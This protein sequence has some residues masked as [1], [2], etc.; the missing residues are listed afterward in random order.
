MTM[1]TV[2]ALFDTIPDARHAVGALLLRKYDKSDIQ[3]VAEDLAQIHD[4]PVRVAQVATGAV[5]AVVGAAALSI[6]YFGPLVATPLLG[7]MASVGTEEID[8]DRWLV[9]E[10]VKIGV[11]GPDASLFADGVRDGGALVMVRARDVN[12]ADVAGLLSD[13]GAVDVEERR[14]TRSSAPPPPG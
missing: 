2:I 12:A 8:D 14:R 11:P 3:I 4:A 5:G 6:P 10:L 13:C 7:T 1:K 9:R